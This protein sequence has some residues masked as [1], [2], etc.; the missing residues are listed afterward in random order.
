VGERFDEDGVPAACDGCGRDA[1][2]SG[3][4]RQGWTVRRAPELWAGT[5][6]TACASNLRLLGSA[7]ECVEC[8]RAVTERKAEVR[9]WRFYADTRG[10]LHP[11]C[12]E[13]IPA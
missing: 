11:H 1:I 5:Y 10:E 13:C 8:G 4:Q 9:G 2:A 6:C 12:P 7:I 3:M